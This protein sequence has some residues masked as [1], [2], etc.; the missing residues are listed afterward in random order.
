MANAITAFSIAQVIAYLYLLT[1]PNVNIEGL[2]WIICVGIVFFHGIYLLGIGGCHKAMLKL[3]TRS[4]KKLNKVSVK[5]KHGQQFIVVL[6]AILAIILTVFY[7]H[8]FDQQNPSVHQL[9]GLVNII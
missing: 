7:S 3:E 1:N 9:K 6:F 4:K 5:I 8:N 2:K